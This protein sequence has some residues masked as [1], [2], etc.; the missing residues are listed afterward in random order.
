MTKNNPYKILEQIEKLV[1]KGFRVFGGYSFVHKMSLYNKFQEFYNILPQELKDNRD[2]FIAQAEENVFSLLNEIN[3][4]LERSRSYLG[5]ILIKVD[6]IMN[7]LD[8]IYAVLPD[9]IKL[10]NFDYTSVEKDYEEIEI[11]DFLK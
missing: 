8:M 3:F 7:K 1:Y 11:P 5:F 4:K 2:V 6:F 9:N 10:R